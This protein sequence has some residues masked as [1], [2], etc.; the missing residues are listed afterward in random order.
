MSVWNIFIVINVKIISEKKIYLHWNFLQLTKCFFVLSVQFSPW[1]GT[2]F[3][4]D[5]NK[6]FHCDYCLYAFSPGADLKRHIKSQTG[7]KLL[8][9][10][11]CLMKM[12]LG[13]GNHEN[14][15]NWSQIF[16]FEID[17]ISDKHFFCNHCQKL[18]PKK[19][20]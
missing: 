15:W 20:M 12:T 18:F 9:S 3:H 7:E 13:T 6:Y 8:Y 10:N 2:K 1:K 19:T 4:F 17:E 14:I 11:H 5:K 16:S